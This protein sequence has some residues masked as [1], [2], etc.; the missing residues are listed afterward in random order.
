MN[1]IEFE[2][3]LAELRLTFYRHPPV[4]ILREGFRPVSGQV[5]DMCVIE[6]QG[7]YHFFYIERRLLEA[8]PFFP[9]NEIY[10]GHASTANLVDWEVHDPV[11]LVRPG[12]WEEAHVW[13]P[14]VF[15]YQG[16]FVMAYT[17]V[18]RHLSQN[19]GLA[20]SDDLFT[21]RRFDTNPIY[22]ARNRPWSYWREDCIASCRDPHLL[23]H[24]GRIWMTYTANTREG[25][26]CIAL[27]STDD[28]VHWEDHGPIL[29]GPKDG[30]QVEQEI[31]RQRVFG[32]GRPQGQLES[33]NLLYRNGRW[34]LFFQSHF[35]GSQGR[36]W[37]CESAH[38][39][40]FSLDKKREFWPGAYTVE[41]VKECGSR[42]L[43]ACTGPIRFGTVDWADEQP[44]ARFI[45]NVDE[46]K[47]W[48]DCQATR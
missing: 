25:A 26:S 33:S 32:N 17:G 6:H 38:M 15:R 4:D 29:V 3:R 2:T 36:N 40:C 28:L 7:R 23:E 31:S 41:I 21:W 46:L 11:L 48:Q 44:V 10:F 22:P 42:A 18:N 14:F 45:S 16:R 13:A 12:T 19:I 24:D 47:A 34:Y 35:P 27:A 9:G 5:G 1:S 39:E 43:L 30:Y 37:V 8:T 20:E